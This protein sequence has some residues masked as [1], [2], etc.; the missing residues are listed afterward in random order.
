MPI[1]RKLPL[2]TDEI[3]GRVR[4]RSYDVRTA[5]QQYA[6]IAGLLAGFAFTVVILIAQENKPALSDV[7][8]LR[9]NIAAVGF[10]C[11][12][13]GCVLN[14]FVFALISGE[15]ALTPRANQMAFFAA[16]SFS[17]SI[18]LLFWSIA[19]IL[20]AFLVEEVAAI[21]YK[22]F[23]LFMMIHPIYVV[24]SILDNVYIFE[25]RRP[26][27]REY[28]VA[29]SPSLVP[30][31]IAFVLRIGRFTINAELNLNVFYSVIWCLLVMI[32]LGNLA[33]AAS[34]ALSEDFQLSFRLSSLWVC[35]HAI[36]IS[37][38]I[39]LV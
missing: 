31:L 13:F 24:S 21:S 32:V 29:I 10:F 2:V 9:R 1:S 39:V 14:S 19:I 38:L 36:L 27:F 25:C 34:S 28:L 15:E 30:I 12:F 6:N 8:V 18:S 11:S 5:S 22:I 7:E 35:L 37:F 33:A 16:A 3:S 4:V 23:P 20:K 17:L 26:R